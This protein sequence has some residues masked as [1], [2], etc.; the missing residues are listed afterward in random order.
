MP[1]ADINYLAVIAAAFVNMAVGF[2]WYS[3]KVFGKDW[4]KE[5]GLSA[6]D[7]GNGPGV[8]YAITMLGA[9]LQAYV[10]AHAVDYVSADT[11]AEGLLTGLWLGVGLV[12]TSIAANYIFAQRSRKLFFIDAGYFVTTLALNGILLAVWR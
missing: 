1:V 9:L 12:A 2:V 7:I 6:K 8:G 10:L 4:M 3:L 5:V 11:L